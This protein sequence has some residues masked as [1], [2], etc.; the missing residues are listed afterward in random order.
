MLAFQ[1]DHVPA[2]F[3]FT[4]LCAECFHEITF[5]TVLMDAK[6]KDILADAYD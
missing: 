2:R 5:H 1:I 4:G 3:H 6:E